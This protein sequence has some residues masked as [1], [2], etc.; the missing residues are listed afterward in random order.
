MIMDQNQGSNLRYTIA[1][2]KDEDLAQD[3]A[4]LKQT[5]STLK[6]ELALKTSQM[7]ELAA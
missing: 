7:T 6:K 1:E 4:S 3:A 2:P 5:V